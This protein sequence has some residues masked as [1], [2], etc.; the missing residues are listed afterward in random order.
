MVTQEL[1]TK[2]YK[3]PIST[4]EG[5]RVQV[6]Q[7]VGISHISDD[8]AQVSMN[9]ISNI[10]GIPV[11]QLKRNVGETCFMLVKHE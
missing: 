3:V 7:A 9:R 11:D 5:K 10:F 6:V 4:N 1:D 8:I 2:L